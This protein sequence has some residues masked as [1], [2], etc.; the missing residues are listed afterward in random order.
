MSY[1]RNNDTS[2]SIAKKLGIAA[3][4]AAAA[5]GVIGTGIYTFAP[6]VT[7]RDAALKIVRGELVDAHVERGVKM[8]AIFPH[9][10][11]IRLPKF[12]QKV[13]VSARESDDVTIRTKEDARI[14][15]VFEVH[16]MLENDDPNF[17][18]IYTELK[19]DEIADIEPFIR[20]YT[21][22]AAIDVYKMVPTAS[23]NDNLTDIG[24]QLKKRLQDILDEHGY[25]YIRVKDVVPSGVG[26]SAKAN[27]DLE[28]IVSENRKLD[29]MKVQTQ[30]ADQSLALTEKQAAVTAKAISELQKA[31]VPDDQLIQAYY[32]QLMRDNNSIGKEFV[33]GPVPGTGVGAVPVQ[34][35]SP[36]NSAPAR[37][38]APAP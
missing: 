30:V 35:L 16:Y 3:A 32:L 5:A 10:E 31:G 14:Y 6:R 4:F 34:Q 8:D 15:G 9:V 38:P 28:S 29:L 12:L 37:T 13:A 36:R 27:A 26:L 22:P 33:P 20:N 24:N 21:I 18:N 7:E 17:T 25:T 2:S 19:A 11:Y 23:V 1:E